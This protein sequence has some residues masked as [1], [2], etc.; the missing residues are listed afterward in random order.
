MKNQFSL[1]QSLSCVWLFATPWTEAP[2]SSVHGIL[3]AR[4]LEWIAMPSSRHLPNP[5]IEPVSSASQ[6]DSLLLNHRGSLLIHDCWNMLNV[7]SLS[8]QFSSVAQFCPTFCDPMNCST[9]GLPVHHQLPRVHSDSRASSQWC[10]PA[11]SSS[12]VPFSS[13]PRSLP[14]SGSFPISQLFT[15]GGQSTGVS[16]SASVLP[17]NT[18]DWSPLGWTGWTSLQSKGLS[19]FSPTPQC[20]SINY[21]AISFLYSPILTSRRDYWKNQSFN[22]MENFNKFNK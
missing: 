10:H 4:M 17:M 20:K 19:K 12:I 21:L 7:I 18:Q 16:A 5:G 6:A 11:I 15:W 3:Q 13:W 1:V 22:W 14:A 9:L 2:G 8:V